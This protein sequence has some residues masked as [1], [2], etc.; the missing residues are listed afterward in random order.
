MARKTKA[1][2]TPFA[3]FS[4][5]YEL[6]LQGVSKVAGIDEVGRGSLAGPVVVAIVL[7]RSKDKPIPGVHDSKRLT[8][9]QR[10]K[11]A[12][13]IKRRFPTSVGIVDNAFIDKYGIRK[14]VYAAT[15]QAYWALPDKPDIALMDGDARAIV[16]P[17]FNA[18]LMSGGDR[19]SFSIAAASIVA[20]VERDNL[21]KQLAAKYQAYNWHKNVGYGTKEHTQAILEYGLSPYHRKSYCKF[22]HAR[23]KPDQDCT[24]LE[25][26][27]RSKNAQK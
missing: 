21:M 10:E 4:L 18:I 24:P 12:A 20:K 26:G 1:I 3:S 23:S 9:L 16:V 7:V 13:Q 14:A 2:R 27:G 22:I 17:P 8:P 5:E 11:L 15:L 19:L 25:R 6:F